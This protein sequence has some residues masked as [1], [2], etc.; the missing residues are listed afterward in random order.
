MRTLS[1]ES[2]GEMSMD[3]SGE[4]LVVIHGRV[5]PELKG[6]LEAAG[7]RPTI[8]MGSFTVWTGREPEPTAASASSN[9]ADH[10][11]QERLLL[12]VVEAA[13]VL[14]IGRTMTYQLINR[15]ELE[16]V[17]IGR[18]VRVPADSLPDVVKGLRRT[19]SH[20]SMRQGP[21]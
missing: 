20:A 1:G 12:T 13:Q 7:L 4:T 3:D 17:H 9:A 8:L 16:V 10:G 2:E 21:P 11:R 19:G 18:S 15:G 14:G 5:R 6:A